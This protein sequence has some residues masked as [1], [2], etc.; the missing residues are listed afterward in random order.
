MKRNYERHLPHQVP[1]EAMLF[2]T[3]NLKGA[4]PPEIVARLCRQRERLQREARRS[5]DTE[6]D[7]KLRHDKLIFAMADRYLGRTRHGP[8]WLKEPAAAKIVEDAILFGVPERYGLFAWCVMANH[9]HVLLKARWELKDI[10]Q[11]LKGYTAH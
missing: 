6:R 1:E 7:R 5:S 4:F 8:I 3:W 10:T 2:L 9:V 11:G